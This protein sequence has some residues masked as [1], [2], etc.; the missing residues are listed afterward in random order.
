LG[1]LKVREEKYKGEHCEMK[2]D[3]SVRESIFFFFTF[4]K[5]TLTHGEGNPQEIAIQ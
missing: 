4:L 3:S 2:V 5:P 1:L